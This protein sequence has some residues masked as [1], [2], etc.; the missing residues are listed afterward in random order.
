MLKSQGLT[1]S[2]ADPCLYYRRKG[3]EFLVDDQ[4]IACN[5][6]PALDDFK[7]EM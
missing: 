4:L 6:G 7:C 3:D 2:Q 1:R 5:N